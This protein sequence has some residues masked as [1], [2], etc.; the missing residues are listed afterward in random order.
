MSM[1]PAQRT[2]L[3]THA[4]DTIKY[5]RQRPHD[6]NAV[7]THIVDRLPD[8][9]K[10]T[11]MDRGPHG[12]DSTSTVERVALRDINQAQLDL[13]AYDEACHR[14]MEAVAVLHLL[15]HRYPIHEP[16]RTVER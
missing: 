6:I 2:H 11:T 16:R 4:A 14:L 3:M 9:L 13:D 1:S 7:R 15:S 12:G 8:G 10:A 5:L